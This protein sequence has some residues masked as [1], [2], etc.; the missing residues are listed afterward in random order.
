MHTSYEMCVYGGEVMVKHVHCILQ[1]QSDLT[2]KTNINAVH[3]KLIKLKVI[4][5]KL[6]KDK[7]LVIHVTT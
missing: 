4:L 2:K 6:T 1:Y 3:C 7:C 5:F